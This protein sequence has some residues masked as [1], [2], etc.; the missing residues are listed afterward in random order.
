MKYIKER[1]T[2]LKNDNLR[3]GDILM[4]RILELVRDNKYSITHYDEQRKDT[5]LSIKGTTFSKIIIGDKIYY[6]EFKGGFVFSDDWFIVI[7]DKNKVK[8]VDYP[9]HYQNPIESKYEFSGGLYGK[10]ENLTKGVMTDIP[11]IEIP[12]KFLSD[13]KFI[14]DLEELNDERIDANKYN[15]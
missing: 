3:K 12:E 2:F 15:L 8:D 11:E 10:F 13:T 5:I 7:Y 9:N 4:C 14:D 6:M 1:S